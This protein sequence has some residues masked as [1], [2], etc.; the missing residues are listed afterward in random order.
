MSGFW[1]GF[2]QGIAPF[3]PV[4]I[5]MFVFNV[6]EEGRMLRERR[7]RNEEGRRWRIPDPPI[8]AKSSDWTGR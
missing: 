7:E 4:I 2:I 1:K 6:V 3:I 8:V 5:G